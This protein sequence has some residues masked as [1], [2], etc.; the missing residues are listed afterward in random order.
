[1]ETGSVA[2]AL[3]YV[4]GDG[5]QRLVFL[6]RSVCSVGLAVAGNPLAETLLL[7]TLLAGALLLTLHCL[8]IRR[9]QQM[10]GQRRLLRDLCRIHQLS[11]AER[12]LLHQLA[13]WHRL[14]RTTD[15]FLAP[16]RFE[17]DKLGPAFANRLARVEALRLRL[18]GGE[19]PTARGARPP[20][21]ASPGP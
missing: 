3:W 1:M 6:D 18:F 12:R 5:S 11:R 4:L 9:R 15:L 7:L 20:A 19:V 8:Q 14:P 17:A 16:E 2:F 21:A 10:P 13:H